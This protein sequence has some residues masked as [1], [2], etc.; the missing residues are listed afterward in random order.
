[1]PKV[2]NKPIQCSKNGFKKKRSNAPKAALVWRTGQCPVHQGDRLRTRHLREFWRPLRYNSPDCPVGHWTVRCASGVMAPCANGRLQRNSKTLQCA[3]ACI[4]QSRR[5][6]AHRTVNSDCPVHHR[7]VRWPTC[8]KL[9]WSEPNDLVTWLAHRTVWCARRQK[10]SPTVILV[11][12]A[13]NTPNHPH[14]FVSKFT[15]IKPHTRALYFIPRHKRKDQILSQV[16]NHSKQNN[17]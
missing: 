1:V 5:Q 11:V 14:F 8:Q 16:R 4:S 2:H 6:K 17:D 7:T 9:Q 13:I 10:P 3:P 15:A 12:G